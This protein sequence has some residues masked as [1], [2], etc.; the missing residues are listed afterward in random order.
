LS[1]L[2]TEKLTE[3]EIKTQIDGLDL[4]WQVTSNNE[5]KRVFEFKGFYKT[6]GF[7]NS[8]AWIA[9]KE[10]HH[11]DLEISYNKC[12]VKYTTHDS[13][14]LTSKD[15]NCIKQIEALLK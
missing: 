14:G 2:Q 10:M 3:K 6:M 12:T 15:F 8:I 5:L 7:V 9:Q 13:G 4:D 11:P 1:N